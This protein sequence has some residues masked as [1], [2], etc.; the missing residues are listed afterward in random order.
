MDRIAIVGLGPL[1]LSIGLAL[2]RAEL[3]DAE[4]VGIDRAR[5]LQSRASKM[6]AVDS[7]T[8]NL[9]SALRGAGLV[10]L[11]MPVLHMEE[12]L[13]AVGEDVEKGTTVTD[14]G[15]SKV[16]VT[17]WAKRHLPET[18]GFVGGRPLPWKTLDLPEDAEATVFDDTSYCVVPSDSTDPDSVKTVVGLVEVLRGGSAIHGPPRAR[19]L[20]SGSL[21]P[22]PSALRGAAQRDGLQRVLERDVSPCRREFHQLSGL[23]AGDPEETAAASQADSGSLDHWLGQV[24]DELASYRERLRGQDEN[25]AEV[26]VSA[27]EHRARW[28][29]G[30]VGAENRA[31]VPSAKAMMA[32]MFL[33]NR[34]VDRYSKFADTTKPPS[35]RYPGAS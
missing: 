22:A 10:I 9:R 30:E 11:D 6:G 33:G 23:A 2:K 29:A 16:K 13:Q 8:G 28:E 31:E 35:W 7:A 24:I 17:E 1:G 12:A 26:L 19:L 15:T 4:V 5:N 25:L 27:W 18:A 14:T 3:T 21:P 34:L 32:G 20:R